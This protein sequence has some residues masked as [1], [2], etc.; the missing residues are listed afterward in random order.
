MPAHAPDSQP[1]DL[2]AAESTEQPGKYQC[3][4]QLDGM[5]AADRVG[6][7]VAVLQVEARPQQFGPDVIGDHAWVRTDESADAARSGQRASGIEPSGR[8]NPTPGSPGR[9]G[10]PRY[11]LLFVRGINGSPKTILQGVVILGVVANAQAVDGGNPSRAQ[12]SRPLARL[13]DLGMLGSQPAPH[14]QHLIAP[15]LSAR[16]GK[17]RGVVPSL[18]P[19]RPDRVHA[20]RRRQ[21]QSPRRSRR[22]HIPERG[23]RPV[24][25]VDVLAQGIRDRHVRPQRLQRVL[26][27]VDQ[28]RAAVEQQRMADQARRP[29]GHLG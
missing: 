18:H 22:A 20:L 12:L 7:D 10:V 26:G 23:Q 25:A 11:R 13:P 6:V 4:E 29:H 17:S 27:Q 21:R 1:D 24:Q 5:L 14:P 2:V 3:S 28:Q 8:T 19:V 16:R 9:T 15:A